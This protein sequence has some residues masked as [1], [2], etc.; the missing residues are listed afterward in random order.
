M[1]RQMTLLLDDLWKIF[2]MSLSP[3]CIITNVALMCWCADFRSEVDLVFP[4]KR[5]NIFGKKEKK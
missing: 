4:I 2:L 1:R 5:Y 3:Y